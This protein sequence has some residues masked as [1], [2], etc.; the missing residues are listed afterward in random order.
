MKNYWML[1]HEMEE[2]F[3]MLGLNRRPPQWWDNVYM[4]KLL[5]MARIKI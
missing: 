3:D 5:I 2:M 1:N 4:M